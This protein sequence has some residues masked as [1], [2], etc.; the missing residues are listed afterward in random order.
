MMVSITGSDAG[1]INDFQ[2]SVSFTTPAPGKTLVSVIGFA[3]DFDSP[4]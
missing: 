2:L 1:H 4:I 3:N